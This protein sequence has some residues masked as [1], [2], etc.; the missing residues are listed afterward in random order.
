MGVA[1]AGP[2]F[3]GVESAI[4]RWLDAVARAYEHEW[5]ID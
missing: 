4:D 3:S 1:A 5:L 2:V